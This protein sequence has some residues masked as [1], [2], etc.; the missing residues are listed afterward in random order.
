MARSTDRVASLILITWILSS[1]VAMLS[2]V[3]SSSLDV[4]P[5]SVF[6]VAWLITD[7][8]VA[9]G[10]ILSLGILLPILLTR[11]LK[12]YCLALFGL[13]AALVSLFVF[14]AANVHVQ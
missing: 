8:I 6:R 11:F 3:I 9:L 4:L 2:V 10:A 5:P 13:C 14:F 1:C 7:P 12:W